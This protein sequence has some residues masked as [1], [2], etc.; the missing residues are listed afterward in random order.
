MEILRHGALVLVLLL[1]V[2]CSSSNDTLTGSAP[3]A[4]E[5]VAR[6]AVLPAV[7]AIKDLEGITFEEA[8]VL[9]EGAAFVTSVLKNELA[10]HP[11]VRFVD[12]YGND[13][14]NF[15][16]PYAVRTRVK[17]IG[18]KYACEAVL[19]T[20]VQRFEQRVGGDLS[21]DSPASA[22]VTLQLIA[23]DTGRTLWTGTF[24]ETQQSLLSNLLSFGQAQTRGF[25][26]I[27]VEE[28]V[29]E[30]IKEQLAECPYL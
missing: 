11:K 22:F 16:N 10:D 9:D 8:R 12:E 23:T 6:I 13:I 1:L 29:T 18:E 14:N 27:T 26:W 5:T 3:Q 21:V 15:G 25:Q 2:S 30:G 17:E 19:L 4:V 7:S 24:K 20:S 28:M